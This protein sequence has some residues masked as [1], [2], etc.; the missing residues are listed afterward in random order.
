MRFKKNEPFVFDQDAY[1]KLIKRALLLNVTNLLWQTVY[2]IPIV[3]F[4]SIP[5]IGWFTPIF[6]I[7]MECYF[8]RIWHVGLWFGNG[9][10]K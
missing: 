6:T 10:E 3:L 7:L 1:K 5:L 9:K 4:C 8:F 2:L